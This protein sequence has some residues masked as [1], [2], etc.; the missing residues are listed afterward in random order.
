MGSNPMD[1]VPSDKEYVVYGRI[2][3]KMSLKLDDHRDINVMK[4]SAIRDVHFLHLSHIPSFI[5]TCRIQIILTLYSHRK[6]AK[7]IVHSVTKKGQKREC[8][9]T[10]HLWHLYTYVYIKIF[11]LIL[12]V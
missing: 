5:L 1:R 2:S 6:L 11:N 3:S 4:N 7:C 10:L 8:S 12:K 9:T